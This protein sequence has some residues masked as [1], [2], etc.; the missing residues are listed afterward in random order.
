METQTKRTN[1]ALLIGWC[2]IVFV[3]FFMYLMEVFRGSRTPLYMVMFSLFTVVPQVAVSLWYMRRPDNEKIQY[4]I[5]FGYMLMYGFVLLTA[6]TSQVWTYIIPMLSL[7]VLYHNPVLIQWTT[8]I[9]ILLNIG[10][11]AYRY[12]RGDITDLLDRDIRIQIGCLALC[13]IALYVATRIY[14]SSHDS[15]VAYEHE[16]TAQKEELYQQAEELEALNGELNEYADN[17]TKKNEE[18]RKMSMQT[19]MTI[20]NTIDAKDEYTRGHS[21]RVAEYSAR[22]A[23]EL[24]FQGDELRDIRFIGLLHDIGKIG[25]PDNV[26]NKAGKLSREEYL[27]M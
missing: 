2:V 4:Y 6:N 26:L 9:A 16:L 27:L 18:L 14:K 13:F 20:A 25:V 15:N 10:E 21:R 17:L 7:L 3:L 22:I 5:V 24:G 12:I 11:I 1:R 23:E 19:I 8:I